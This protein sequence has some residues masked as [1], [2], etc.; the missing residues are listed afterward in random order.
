MGIGTALLPELRETRDARTGRRIRQFTAGA[1]HSYPLYYFTP[2]I[3]RDGRYLVMH[4]I[5]DG[6]L[7][8]W[9]LDL[10]DGTMV[11][12]TDGTTREAG[13]AIWGEM[14][15]QGVYDHLGTLN[16]VTREVWYFDRTGLFAARL[17]TLRQRQ[18]WE[19]G[20]RICISQNDF[21]PDGCWFIFVHADRRRYQEAVRRHSWERHEAWRQTVPVV[22]GVI[23]VT[24]GDY[25]TVA[26]LPC[27]VHHAVFI[28]NDSFL[29]NHVPGRLGMWRMRLDGCD[30]GTLRPADAHGAVC[31]Q[32]VTARGIWY[33]TINGTATPRTWV[34]R[35][36]LTS[37]QWQ[38]FAV[39]QDGYV[40]IGH[41]PAG[42]AA[43][44]EIDG[45]SHDLVRVHDPFDDGCRRFEVLCTLA[46]YPPH[47]GGQ[48]YHA[49]P[50]LGP[51][52]DWVYHTRVV[53]GVSQVAAVEW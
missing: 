1:G 16:R 3:T 31:H 28:D 29:L 32:S 30:L 18:V 10:R 36:D 23:D 7:N 48:R 14:D 39:L 38:E 45:P 34:G 44:Y 13:W 8:L 46:P 22:V 25:R 52:R 42:A 47:T 21:S 26:E 41:D 9:R 12:L 15:V 37:G 19:L 6:W 2:S 5:Q 4:R 17:D 35:Y 51:A 40:H 49:H 33:E 43:F 50:F 24:T 20:D 11:Q 27:H 53:G